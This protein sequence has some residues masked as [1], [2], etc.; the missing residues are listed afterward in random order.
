[1]IQTPVRQATTSLVLLL[2]LMSAVWYGMMI[3]NPLYI[4]HPVAYM[5]LQLAEVLGMFQLIGAWLS[6]LIAPQP[7]ETYQIQATK[8]ALQ[9]NPKL[10]G[11]VVVFVP[12]AGEPIDIIRQTVIAAREIRLPHRTVV[13]DDGQSSD[14]LELSRNLGV[15][16]FS[17]EDREGWKAGNINFGLSKVES[18]FFAVIDSDF[19]AKPEFLEEMLAPLL[20]DAKLAF[21]QSPQVYGNEDNFVA[22]GSSQSQLAFYR[23][24]QSAK[25]SFNSV[26]SVGTNVVYR[27]AAIQDIGG[28][29]AKSHS[30]DIWTSILLHERGWKSFYLPQ[31]LAIGLAPESFEAYFRQQFRWAKGGFEVLLDRMPLFSRRLSLDQRLQYFHTTAHFTTGISVLIFFLLPLFYV[32]F[33]WKPL[34]IPYASTWFLH[35]APY[36]ILTF[37]TTTHLMGAL[38]RWRA[39][40][41]SMSAFP[42]HIAAIFGAVFGF[43]MR[44][45]ASGV[46]RRNIDYIKSVALHILLLLLSLGAVPVLYFTDRGDI[47]V[48]G[49]MTFWLCL[50]SLVLFSICKRAIPAHAKRSSVS[51][52]A[53]A[54]LA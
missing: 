32:Y 6:I 23:H 30:E 3:F 38:P 53:A 47:V 19:I 28:M 40:V 8:H 5:L 41:V 4:G 12:V 13:L 45:R 15:E 31:T 7:A 44:W 43:E 26:F 11:R 1:M 16:Y 46:L 39:I 29:Y 49:M 50:N 17:R 14:V 54:V 42:Y 20:V 22:G 36:Y 21:V 34:Q 9:R 18:D 35:F 51:F 48:M 25:N 2:T 24:L 37:V 10:P 33:G 27:T 52:S